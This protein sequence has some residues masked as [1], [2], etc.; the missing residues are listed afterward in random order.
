[1]DI[2]G[3]VTGPL[4]KALPSGLA[5]K[6]TQGGITNLG[7]KLP[8]GVT[9]DKGVAKL[10]NPIT[11][12]R[13][14]AEMSFSGGMRMDGTLDLPGTVSLSPRAGPGY[15]DPLDAACGR[16]YPH[17]T[18]NGKSDE[19]CVFSL[20]DRSVHARADRGHCPASGGAGIRRAFAHA[21]RRR[22]RADAARR[23]AFG[24]ALPGARLREAGG[25]TAQPVVLQGAREQ[26][27]RGRA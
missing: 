6:T 26:A 9:I 2:L 15:K 3:S 13:P 20:G 22:N 8:F 24:E 25:R 14:E 1:K 17:G 19:G 7:Q 11:I 10:K 27:F 4:S 16:R 21:D 18:I 12:S 5:G 23:Q